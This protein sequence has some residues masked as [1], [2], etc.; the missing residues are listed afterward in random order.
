CRAS[1]PHGVQGVRIYEDAADKWVR[2]RSIWSQHA[3]AVTHV[4]EDGT[5]PRTS[6]WAT[7]WTQSGLNNFRQNVP[8]VV[9]GNALGDLTGAVDVTVVPND[10]NASAECHSE[11]NDGLVRGVFCEP[12][13]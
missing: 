11:N 8:G 10:G 5:V 1:H 12:P 3:Y 7:N 13:K 9:N 4:N 2:S 6:Q